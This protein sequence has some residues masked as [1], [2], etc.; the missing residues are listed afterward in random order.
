MEVTE[1]RGND[2]RFQMVSDIHLEFEGAINKMPSIPVKA[3]IIALLGKKL[4]S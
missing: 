4:F 3:P 1:G 2:V